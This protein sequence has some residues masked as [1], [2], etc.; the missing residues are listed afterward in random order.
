MQQLREL[1]RRYQASG[2][3]DAAWFYEKQGLPA[4]RTLRCAVPIRDGHEPLQPIPESIA[5]RSPH[6]YEHLGAP[7]GDTRPYALRRH[8]L[9]R[10]VEAQAHL[11][12]LC[13][14]H[15]LQIFDAY[16][17]LEVQVFMIEH[18]CR[19]YAL[20]QGWD[21]QRLSSAQRAACLA[22]VRLFWAAPNED[23]TQP[24]PHSTGAAIDLTIVDAQGVPL[25]MGTPIDHVG[26][27]STPNH[28]GP[29]TRPDERLFHK[30]RE[31][32]HQVM[33]RAGFRRLP[34]EWWHFSYGDQWW[35]LLEYLERDDVAPTALYGRWC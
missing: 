27:Q 11:D 29:A 10:L 33:A 17:P 22:E 25:P 6:P 34:F 28:Y 3:K 4:D 2:L 31:Q 24:P 7:Y 18:E 21:P 20:A 12:N 19:Q 30:N 32:L 15:R 26:P 8:V 5:R 13:P 16:R 14:G 9:A 1:K 23:P 35:A